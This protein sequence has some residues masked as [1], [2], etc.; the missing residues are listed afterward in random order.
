MNCFCFS[1]YE[2]RNLI[3]NQFSTCRFNVYIPTLTLS[4]TSIYG[5]L[6][7]L[8][9]RASGRRYRTPFLLGRKT[10]V[11]VVVLAQ[12]RYSS[13]GVFPFLLVGACTP[14][15]GSLSSSL[16]QVRLASW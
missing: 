12:T 14:D 2:Y 11:R 16:A 9:V 10:L 3:V 4:S 8:G 7:L 6:F 15:L 13:E 1:R 5:M